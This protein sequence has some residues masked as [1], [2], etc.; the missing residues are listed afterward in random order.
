MAA[1][2]GFFE[3]S[4][5]V[6]HYFE[7]AALGGY[8]FHLSADETLAQLSRQTDGSRPVVSNR[9]VFD[10]YLHLSAP[11]GRGNYRLQS[12]SPSNMP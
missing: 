6:E 10:R 1:K 3:D 2:H 4:Y 7:P 9:A 5:A 11:G 8:Q 12:V